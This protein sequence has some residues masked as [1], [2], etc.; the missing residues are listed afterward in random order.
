M[1]F[2]AWLIIVVP[3]LI[4]SMIIWS[5]QEIISSHIAY[6]AGFVMGFGIAIAIGYIF[7]IFV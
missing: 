7:E 6:I 4:G 1:I 2:L 3:I 5:S